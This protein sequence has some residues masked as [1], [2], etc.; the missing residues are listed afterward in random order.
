MHSE[1]KHVRF[2][3]RTDIRADIAEGPSC[4]IRRPEQVQRAYS[5]TSSARAD[6]VGGTSMPS[7]FAVLR[8]IT[9]SNLVDC[10]IG[11]SAGLVPWRMRPA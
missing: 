1:Y 6:S 5:T 8:L 11:R 3:P 10:M 2:S 7:A 9:N 4:A